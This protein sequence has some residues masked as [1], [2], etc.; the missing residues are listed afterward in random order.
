[1]RSYRAHATG[2]RADDPGPSHTP[3]L[4]ESLP[5]YMAVVAVLHESSRPLLFLLLGSPLLTL[6]LVS[7]AEPVLVAA[8]RVSMIS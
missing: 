8:D 7:K 4:P 1:M 5:H 6:G 2:H 3:S